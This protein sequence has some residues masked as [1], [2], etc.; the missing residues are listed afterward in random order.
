[1]L[2]AAYKL[3]NT[4]KPSGSFSLQGKVVFYIL[5]AAVQWFIGAW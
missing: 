2:T 3:E 4:L 5:N 1:M